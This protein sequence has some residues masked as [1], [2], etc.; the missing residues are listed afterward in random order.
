MKQEYKTVWVFRKDEK[1]HQLIKSDRFNPEFHKKLFWKN[2]SMKARK[3]FSQKKINWN[4]PWIV[5]SG[6]LITTFILGRIFTPNKQMN[7]ISF[8]PSEITEE[9]SED[10]NEYVFGS[11]NYYVQ[12]LTDMT[13]KVI[14]YAVT[15]RQEDFNPTITILQNAAYQK[16]RKTIM[17]TTDIMLGKSTFSDLNKDLEN[18]YLDRPDKILV[19][20]GARRFY[21]QE[22]YYFGNPGNYQSYFFVIN[23]AGIQNFDKIP[24]SFFES[25]DVDV[26]DPEVSEFR[27]ES[28]FNTFQVTAPLEGFNNSELRKYM[29]GPDSDQMRVIPESLLQKATPKKEQLMNLERLST[30]VDIQVFVDILGNPLVVNN[31]PETFLRTG[32]KTINEKLDESRGAREGSSKIEEE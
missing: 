10:I 12:A 27:K 26:Q 18:I 6:L 13:N 15:T 3:Y 20:I 31:K 5:G 29:A 4:N 16:D 7:T 2:L 8:S 22:E 23:D 9:V 21:Y 24:S 11:E 14:A 19:N 25:T 17:A 28:R 30:E 1:T 32:D